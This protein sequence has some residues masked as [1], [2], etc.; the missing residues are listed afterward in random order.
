MRYRDLAKRLRE[1]GCEEIVGGKGSH[2]KWHNSANGK[3]TVVP[4]WGNKDL[5]P[6]TVR[7]VVRELGISRDQLG[8]RHSPNQIT[9]KVALA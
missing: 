9:I 7:A 2:R 4:D 3:V 5:A 8:A 6:G 1:L